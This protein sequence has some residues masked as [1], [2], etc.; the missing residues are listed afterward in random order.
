MN[1]LTCA[2]K[3]SAF[4]KVVCCVCEKEMHI[5]YALDYVF[6]KSGLFVCA[7][8]VDRLARENKRTSNF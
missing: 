6:T 4:N 1:I 7:D 2:P 5:D 3:D 8:C